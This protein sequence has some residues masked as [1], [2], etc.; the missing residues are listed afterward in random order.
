MSELDDV[1]AVTTDVFDTLFGVRAAIRV[2]VARDE[3]SDGNEIYRILIVFGRGIKL[4]HA[5]L[6]NVIRL[7]CAKLD[8]NAPFPLISFRS[9]D[10][11]PKVQSEAA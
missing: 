2:E 4:D 8:Q 5:K 7:V 1:K 10:D 6:G 9:A 11:D 3:D